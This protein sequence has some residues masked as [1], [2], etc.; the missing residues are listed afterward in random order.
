MLG[1]RSLLAVLPI[2]YISPLFFTLRLTK[3]SFIYSILAYFQTMKLVSIY[4][5]FHIF[6]CN[7]FVKKEKYHEL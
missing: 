6:S 4:T 1:G 3:W 7:I 5:P 2:C